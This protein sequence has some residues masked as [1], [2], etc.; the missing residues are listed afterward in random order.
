MDHYADCCVNVILDKVIM[1]TNLVNFG[2]VTLKS[3]CLFAWMVTV[4]RLKY[5]VCWF[6]NVTH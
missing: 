4:H 3:C 2:A 1:A 5:T 6:F